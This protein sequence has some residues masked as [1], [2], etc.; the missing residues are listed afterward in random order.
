MIVCRANRV[1]HI[2]IKTFVTGMRH[3]CIGLCK[4][5]RAILARVPGVK[6][7]SRRE[8]RGSIGS[9]K[10]R[11]HRRTGERRGRWVGEGTE[12]RFHR[13]GGPHPRERARRASSG[14]WPVER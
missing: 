11:A 8:G 10:T 5:P 14:T 3:G 2:A 12:G 4:G 13:E 1:R 7:G 6:G 9:K